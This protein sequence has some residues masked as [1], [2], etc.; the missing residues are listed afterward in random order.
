[1][2]RT[3]V[4]PSRAAAPSSPKAFAPPIVSEVLSAPGHQLDASARRVV[5]S[6]FHRDFSG[7]RVHTG[8]RAAESARSVNALAYTV[9]RDVVFGRG[10]YAPETAAGRR[11]LAH[12]LTHVAQQASIRSGAEGD[13]IRLGDARDVSENEAHAAS[14]R[15]LLGES[16]P[17]ARVAERERVLRRFTAYDGVEQGAGASGGWVH[18]SGAALRVSDD[19]WLV[20]ED[21]G[22][23]ANLSKRAWTTASKIADSNSR[24][25]AQGSRVKLVL[26]GGS[27]SGQAPETGEARHLTEIEP[28]NAA[29]GTL[30]LAS[31]CGSAC[32]QVM[33]TSGGKDAAVVN[34]EGSSGLGWGVG[35]G[36][37]GGLAGLGLGLL[38]GFNPLLGLGIGLVAGFLGGFFGSREKAGKKQLTPHTYHGGNPT[39]PEEWSEELFKMEFG[40]TLTREEA[41]A[42]YAGLSSDERDAFDR[43]YGINKYAV[44]E[45]GQGLTVSTEKDMP[46]FAAA[47]AFTWNFHFAA[48]VLKSGE[49]YVTLESAA[50]WPPEAWIFFMYGPERKGQSFHEFQGATATHGTKYSTFVVEP[51][52]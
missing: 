14:A 47:S 27:L 34:T 19:G 26:R 44:P 22:W 31:D 10:Q 9:G 15:F 43:K 7:V 1:M 35:L 30:T 28:V 25:A 2:E 8:E 11:L 49:D 6:S 17:P 40:Q 12:E 48:T 24:L 21:K 45:V 42:R 33:G 4:V 18:P 29:G 16:V 3:S 46:G 41:Y 13:G 32:K 20:T 37:L 5:Q 36:A 50:G 39:T 51:E 52:K 23:G 38:T